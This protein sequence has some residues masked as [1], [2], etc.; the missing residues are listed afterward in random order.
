MS[1]PIA[2]VTG[3]TSGIGREVA[4]TLAAEGMRVVGVGRSKER[5]RQAERDVRDST[6]NARVDFLPA[7]LSSLEEIKRLADEIIAAVPRVDVLVN[8]VGCFTF[9]RMLS[10]DG[11]EMQLA[12]NWLAAFALTGLL[13]PRLQRS[14]GARIVNLSSGSHY[15]GRMHWED[16]GLRRGYRGLKAYDQ[17]KLAMVLFTAELARRFTGPGSPVACAVDPGLVK[18]EIAAK[19]SNAVV[20]LAWKIRTR[21]GISAADAAD[22]VA[23]CATGATSDFRRGLSGSYWKERTERQPSAE[24]R[25]PSAGRRLWQAGEQLSGV[26]YPRETAACASLLHAAEA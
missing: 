13:M 8:N 1:A 14:G 4:R 25:N 22:S 19:S 20:R 23:W 16:L 3:A 21:K 24:A 11:M 2:V 10:V 9:R 12:V 7:D 26:S 15:A 5:C 18:T 17:S 6:G